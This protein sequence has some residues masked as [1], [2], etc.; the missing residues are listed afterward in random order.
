MLDALYGTIEA[1]LLYYKKFV[2]SLTKQGFKLKLY[3]A[4]V[5]NKTI[6][7]KQITICFHVDDCKISHES[8]KDVDTTIDWLQAEYES[9]FED[10][11]GAMKIHRGK[12][13]MH[14]GYVFGLLRKRAIL[15]DN[16]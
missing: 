1:A 10:G 6:N 4:C 7:G 11:S 12:I 8:S 5:A 16:A 14:I 2:K 15:C 9:I 13:H 3:D